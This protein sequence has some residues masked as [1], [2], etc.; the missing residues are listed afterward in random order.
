MEALIEYAALAAGAGFFVL[1]VLLSWRMWTPRRKGSRDERFVP[2][3]YDPHDHH[4]GDDGGAIGHG[5]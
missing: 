4:G 1:I 2:G 5:H 3:N